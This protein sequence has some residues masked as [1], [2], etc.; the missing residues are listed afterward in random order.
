MKSQLT[1]PGMDAARHWARA[2]AGQ[3]RERGRKYPRNVVC[4]CCF[5][6][7]TSK[8]IATHRAKCRPATGPKP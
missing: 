2:H 3:T 8:G 4:P 1:F 6:P 5:R 7:F